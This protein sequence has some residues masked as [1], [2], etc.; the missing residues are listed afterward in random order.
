MISRKKPVSW[1]TLRV[2]SDSNCSERVHER[3]LQGKR[4]SV[5]GPFRKESLFNR[6]EDQKYESGYCR[7][8]PGKTKLSYQVKWYE[9]ISVKACHCTV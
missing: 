2:R 5:A 8:G 3:D 9:V 4:E 7:A 1:W 6:K